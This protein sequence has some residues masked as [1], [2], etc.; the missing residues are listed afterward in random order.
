MANSF[1]GVY[2]FIHDKVTGTCIT[3]RKEEIL[4]EIERQLKLGVEDL[5]DEDQYLAEIN[6]I[7]LEKFLGER[8]EYWLLAI[9][10]AREA[11]LLW[12]QQTSNNCR[13]TAVR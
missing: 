1:T 9:C 10:A 4:Q 3:A 5:L 8:Q 12:K 13:Q 7:D 11:G 6:L 2:R